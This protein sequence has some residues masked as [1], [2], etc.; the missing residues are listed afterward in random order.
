LA[1]SRGFFG[2]EPFSKTNAFLEKN[3]RTPIDWDLNK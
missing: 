2:S 1:A 3:G